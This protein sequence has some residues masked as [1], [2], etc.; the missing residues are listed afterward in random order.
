MDNKAYISINFYFD[1]ICPAAFLAHKRLNQL[2]KFSDII[3]I[4]RPILLGDIF[5]LSGNKPPMRV[6]TKRDYLLHQDYPRFAAEHGIEM[7][8]SP[9]FPLN[10]PNIMLCAVASMHH[11][12]FPEYINTVFD[13]IWV[14]GDNLDDTETFRRV[15]STADMDADALLRSAK[16]LAIRTEM[17][18]HSQMAVDKGVFGAP[19]FFVNDEMYFGKDQLI[20]I[21]K[22]LR[23]NKA[24]LLELPAWGHT[25]WCG[26]I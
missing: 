22:L 9:F 6:K 17:S 2:K 15:L 8:L 19:V 23:S 14:H 21:E 13:A 20:Y 24:P 1:L 3:I 7:Q 4:Y 10:S 25:N 5:R 26:L 18:M 12:C 11:E 16:S